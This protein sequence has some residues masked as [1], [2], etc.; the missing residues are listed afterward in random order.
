MQLYVRQI[1][2]RAELVRR[3]AASRR[4]RGGQQSGVWRRR[5]L[6]VGER[7]RVLKTSTRQWEAACVVA[8]VGVGGKRERDDGGV[9]TARCATWQPPPQCSA[10]VTINRVTDH[11]LYLRERDAGLDL[12]ILSDAHNFPCAVDILVRALITGRVLQ[13]QPCPG[14]SLRLY[15]R[16]PRGRL[17]LYELL[18]S[19]GLPHASQ[20]DGVFSH[21]GRVTLPDPSAPLQCPYSDVPC[22]W[23]SVI[24]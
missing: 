8:V 23:A 14:H 22:Y 16:V 21:I 13:P 7:W 15:H 11:N 24:T 12:F 9:L 19:A 1:A 3:R 10:P 17:P 18:A 5:S 2:Y 6:R 20:Q 4:H